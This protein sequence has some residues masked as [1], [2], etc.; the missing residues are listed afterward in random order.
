M[1]YKV[2]EQEKIDRKKW[3][4]YVSSHHLGT[5]FHTPYYL[6]A[7]NA[8]TGY[9]AIALCIQNE[10]GKIEAILSGYQQQVRGGLL[11]AISR[12][13]VVPQLPLYDGESFL[14]ALLNE[15][16]DRYGK[17]A[18]YT[19]F[20]AQVEDKIF[21]SVT[22][23]MGLD[24]IPHYNIIN[25]CTNNY[26]PIKLVS[27][28]KRRQIR[29]AIKSGVVIEDTPSLE[30]VSDFYVILHDLYVNKVKKPLIDK[31]YFL[32]LYSNN[33]HKEY[34]TKFLLV[35]FEGKV[36]GGIVAPVSGNK[37]IHEHYIAG[38]DYEFREQY[39]SVMATWAAIDYASRNGIAL[40]DFMGAGKPDEDYGVR[41]FKLKFGG[42]L[43]EAGRYEFIPSRVKHAIANKGFSLYQKIVR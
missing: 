35:L 18:V 27:E 37:A 9:R 6:H 28:S 15:F 1:S 12:R 8:Q 11:T 21:M 34:H 2:L 38:L 33:G 25:R 42:E 17:N 13:I 14:Q 36:I 10:S 22:R 39:P 43:L 19:E 32:T 40:F 16:I 26:D 3:I 31:S 4:D 7:I 24:Y 5:F 29:R 23:S 20:R 30:Q 41:D